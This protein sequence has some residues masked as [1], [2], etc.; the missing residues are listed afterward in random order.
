MLIVERID[1]KEKYQTYTVGSYA[2]LGILFFFGPV[3]AITD[4]LSEDHYPFLLRFSTIDYF[5]Q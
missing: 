5:S 4:G 2:A 3:I 1:D